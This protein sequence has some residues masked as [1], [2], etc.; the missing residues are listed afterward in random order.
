MAIN[1]SALSSAYQVPTLREREEKAAF[2]K[3]QAAFYTIRDLM[4]SAA[5]GRIFKDAIASGILE[6]VRGGEFDPNE[7]RQLYH[8]E[9]EKFLV[10]FDKAFA[11]ATLD[12]LVEFA[13]SRWGLSLEQLLELNRERSAR[14]FNR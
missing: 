6:P 14:R 13:E 8:E 7:V 1:L 2:R 5:R 10:E 3:W 11:K 9:W 12:E 4:W